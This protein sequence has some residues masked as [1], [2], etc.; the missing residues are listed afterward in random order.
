MASLKDQ[1]LNIHNT[2]TSS[3]KNPSSLKLNN[4]FFAFSSKSCSLKQ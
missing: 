1:S 3:E 4:S 2:W